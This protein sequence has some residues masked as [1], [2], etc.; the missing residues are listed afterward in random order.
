MNFGMPRK[1]EELDPE[2][3]RR[4]FQILGG[5]ALGHRD[6]GRGSVLELLRRAESQL[7]QDMPVIPLYYYVSRHLVNPAI[8]GFENNVRD[9]HLSRYLDLGSD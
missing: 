4:E 6:E 5:E 8:T 3:L 7:M 1:A 2:I 9:I